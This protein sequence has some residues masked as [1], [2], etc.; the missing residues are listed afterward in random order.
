[1]GF[2]I[3]VRWHLY[4]ES[5][6]RA[7]FLSLARSKSRLCS[8]NHRAGYFSNLACDWLSIVWAYSEQERE[9]QAKGFIGTE[10]YIIFFCLLYEG[11][12]K[13]PFHVNVYRWKVRIERNCQ[14]IFM[15]SEINIALQ[16]SI[17]QTWVEHNG[18]TNAIFPDDGTWCIIFI[19]IYTPC[20]HWQ[21]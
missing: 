17:P 10:Y 18:P 5:A 21:C 7:P 11:R 19:Y 6:P 3:L 15:I 20:W 14:Y 1:M 8:A 12:F 4:I 2:P 13:L 9:K 16:G